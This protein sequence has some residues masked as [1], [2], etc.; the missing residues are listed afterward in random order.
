MRLSLIQRV[1]FGF[2]IV[3]L[4][5]LTISGSAYF[6]QSKMAAQLELTASTLTG[7][8]DKSNTLMLHLQDANRAMMQH[9]NTSSA[10][11][12]QALAFNF[13]DSR[14]KYTDLLA[15]FKNDITNYPQLQ[16]SLDKIETY[17]D[18]MLSRSKQHLAIQDQRISARK[19]AFAELK[20]FDSEWLFFTQDVEE[21]I[22]DAQDQNK[23]KAAWE[24]QFMRDQGNGAMTYLQRSLAIQEEDKIAEYRTELTGY[25][26]RFTEKSKSAMQAMPGI[27]DDIKLYSDLLTR[28]I[29]LPEGLFQLHLSFIALNDKSRQTLVEIAANMDLIGE[30]FSKAIYS[31]RALSSNAVNEAEASAAQSM[32]FNLMMASLSILVSMIVAVTVTRSIK[33]PLTEIMRALE[34]LSAGDLSHSISTRFHSEMGMVAKNINHLKDKLSEVIARIQTS[35]HTINDVAAQ[36]YAMSSQTNQDV[37]AQHVQA[38]SVASAV[39]EMETAVHDVAT[40]ASDT[41]R[42]VS[43]VAE[44]AQKNMGHMQENTAL[45]NE[46]KES[47]LTA[48]EVIQQLSGETQQIGDILHVIQNITEQTNLLALNAAIEAARAGEQGR[49]FAVVAGEV[50]T[51]ANRT[52]DSSAEISVMIKRLQDKASQAVSIMDNNLANA[53]LSV[54]NTQQTSLSLQE[55]VSSLQ[56]INDMSH[57]IASAS[58]QQSCVAK[59]IAENIVS[60]SNMAEK[61]TE[62]A[63]K[64]AQNSGALKE[65]ASEQS[66][67]VDQFHM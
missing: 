41:S 1:L 52:Q 54:S 35:S 17:A 62:S 50:R 10:E 11:E 38:E 46:L 26:Q 61:I 40:H 23:Q 55:M 4:L 34:H 12:R 66:T 45:V 65:L 21:F 63:E 33:V 32:R 19:G 3:T 29:A 53:E 31:I 30:E 42:E 49:G 18:L 59:E 15:S 44:R 43:L 14:K 47:L 58:E 64:S 48:S 27:S 37:E 6:T 20:E 28:A 24:I 13:N 56:V 9:A 16:A 36:S 67:L 8:L 51:L 7:L 5:I 57:S 25:L 60:I 2:S 22:L 39:T